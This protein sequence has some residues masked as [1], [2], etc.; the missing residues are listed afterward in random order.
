MG[1]IGFHA[2]PGTLGLCT[3]KAAGALR[4]HDLGKFLWDLTIEGKLFELGK[5]QVAKVVVPTHELSLIVGGRK[6][7]VFSFL[8]WRR[9]VKGKGP[10]PNDL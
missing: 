7:G 4:W 2:L 1:S 8:W 5:A 3:K 10:L 6:V 9:G